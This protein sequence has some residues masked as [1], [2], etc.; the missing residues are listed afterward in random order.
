MEIMLLMRKDIVEKYSEDERRTL[1]VLL[2]WAMFRILI[3]SL[4]F[5][6]ILSLLYINNYGT[7]AFYT[8]TQQTLNLI[9][10]FIGGIFFSAVLL[11]MLFMAGYTKGIMTTDE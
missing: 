9:T 1:R 2:S 8:S 5:V 11:V 6:S 10:G 7:I 3:Y 4:L